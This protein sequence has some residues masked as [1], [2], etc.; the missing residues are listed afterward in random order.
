MPLKGKEKSEY[1]K[2][3]NATRK[4]EK[5]YKEQ[6]KE[7]QRIMHDVDST[8]PRFK[9]ESWSTK[10]LE[11]L[12]EVFVY[13]HKI[14]GQEVTF[15]DWLKLRDKARK[16]LFWLGTGPLH[17]NWVSRVHQPICDFFVQK[18]FDDCYPEGYT[19]DQFHQAMRRQD[20]EKHRLILDPRG[21]Y[22][23]TIDGVDCTQWLVNC[24]DIRMFIV[25]G[26][27]DN[28]TD[29]LTEIKSYFYQPEGADL[30]DFQLLFPEFVLRGVD[31]RSDQPFICPVRKHAQKNKTLWVNSITATLASQHCDLLKGDD[32]VSDRNSNNEETRKTLKRKFDNA[33]NLLDP[34]GFLDVIGTRYAPDDWYGTR[35]E[36]AA[37][38]ARIKYHCRS[39]LTVKPEF[40]GTPWDELTLEMVDLLFPEK[41]GSSEETF[42][43]LHT[44]IL[45]NLDDFLCFPVGSSV[46]M[47]DWTEKA[48]ESILPGDE[49][50]GFNKGLEKAIVTHVHKKLGKVIKAITETG[51]EIFSTSGHEFLKRINSRKREFGCL[52]IG[53]EVVSVYKPAVLPSPEQQRFLDWLGG[54][55]DGE[56]SCS[57]SNV[58]IYQSGIENPEMCSI[59]RE[60]LN[61][62]GILFEESIDSRRG[63]VNFVLFGGR[64]L[65]IKLLQQCNMAK[66]SRFID[67]LWKSSKCIPESSGRRGGSSYERIISIEDVSEQVVYDITTTTG[68]YVCQGFAVHNCQQMNL[69][70]HIDEIGQYINTFTEE[71]LRA[72]HRSFT[73]IPQIGKKYI[74]VDTAATAGRRADY[75]ACAIVLIEER[76]GGMDPLVWF[77]EIKFGR[78]TDSETAVNIVS[79]TK[80]WDPQCTLIEEIPTTSNLFKNEIKRQQNIQGCAH[81]P[82]M[83]FTPDLKPKAKENRIK[84]LQLLH[85]RGLLRFVT[86]SWVDEMT[87]QLTKYTG[88]KTNRGYRGGR[89]DDIPDAMSYVQK[90]LPFVAGGQTDEEK[91]EREALADKERLAAWKTR[92]FGVS[93]P[94]PVKPVDTGSPDDPR[95]R[96]QFGIP[97]L[98][99][100]NRINN[101]NS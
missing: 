14:L 7:I 77:L 75:S 62:L 96:G 83:W 41:L 22:K 38:G 80:K 26:E 24:P 31:G 88:H 74:F 67:S 76:P 20:R 17:K 84:G 50:V 70:A 86:G 11:A 48:I 32:V 10:Q 64:S 19:L 46:L 91:V 52:K 58:S 45:N 43:F 53:R 35:L 79:L 55:L 29:F 42:E 44:M 90:V 16:D 63:V 5:E 59:I 39:A 61:S 4:Q 37:K 34:W 92:I 57:T 82:I 30:T 8:G 85:E 100:P 12:Y 2:Q 97:G 56:G 33:V 81:T 95:R 27:V 47:S 9:S 73:L 49:I 65:R 60:R 87:T 99:M 54:V 21:G 101:A 36:A 13:G 3:Y 93:P 98:G 66:K 94:I 71:N 40:E 6:N 15:I 25:T 69:P 68:N 72:A 28:A 51:R 89:K 18:N 23:S 1:M 78:W